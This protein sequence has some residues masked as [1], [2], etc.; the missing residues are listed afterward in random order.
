MV[1]SRPPRRRTRPPRSVGVRCSPCGPPARAH[2]PRSRRRPALLRV[3]VRSRRARA[4]ARRLMEERKLGPVVGLGT[5]A[6]FGH[7]ATLARDVVGAALD[8]GCRV[9]DSSPMYGG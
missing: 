3:G 6:T 9:A 2:G 1:A 5:W 7:D 4:E 8:A